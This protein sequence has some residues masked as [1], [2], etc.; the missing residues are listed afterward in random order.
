MCAAEPA[1][2]VDGGIPEPIDDA[3]SRPVLVALPLALR[4]YARTALRWRLGCEVEVLRDGAQTYR[5]MLESIAAAQRTISFE[6]YIL[7]SDSTGDRFKLALVERARAGVK[8]RLIHDAVGSFGISSDWVRDLRAAG[9]EIIAFNPIA[10]WRRKFNL[11]HRD[12]RKILVVDDEVAFTGG[13]NIANDYAS[14]EEGGVGWHDMHCQVRGPIVR[15]LARLFRRN[16]VRSGGA[17]FPLP[18]HATEGN[19]GSLVRLLENTARRQRGSFRRAYV[20]V[21]RAARKTIRI[22]N[23]YFLPDRGLRRALVRAARRGVD[24]QVIVPGRSD[25]KLIEWAS[26]YVLRNLSKQGVK[27]WRWRGV[28]LHAKTAAVDAVW[29]TIGSY[30]FDSQSRFNNLEV[31]VEIMDPAIGEKLM[32]V[33]D[34]NLPNCTAYDEQAWKQLPWWK[35]T[36]AWLGYRLRRFL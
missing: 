31:S 18:K 4:P 13:L 6:T 5:A 12:H 33:F 27:I 2:D 32:A 34:A 3:Q 11:S 1:P 10:V 35:K 25:V 23:A 28:M 30:N 22:E 8:V 26:L 14:V 21:I 29:S 15:D 16:W 19:G 9:I 17:Q 36:F 24:V 20:H 7:A